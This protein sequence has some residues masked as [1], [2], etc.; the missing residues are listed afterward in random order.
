MKGRTTLLCTHN[1]AEAEAL[2]D[3]V[4]ILR[5][6]EVLLHEPLSALRERQRPRT[7]LAALQPAEKLAE[8][9]RA[10][11]HVA[12]VEDGGVIALIDARRDA[13]GLLRSLLHEGIEVYECRPLSA[14]LE[15]LFLEAVAR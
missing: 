13:P 4:V 5:S 12:S 3:D 2:C 14:T 15:E 8:R 11:G 9:V 10:L 1:L 6:G 7:R